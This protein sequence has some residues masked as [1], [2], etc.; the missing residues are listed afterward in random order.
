MPDARQPAPFA[1]SPSEPTPPLAIIAQA[2]FL[3]CSWTWCIGMFLPALLWRDLGPWSFAIFAIP[4]CIGAAAM[5]WVLRKPGAAQRLLDAHG[6]AIAAFSLVTLAFQWFFLAWMLAASGLSVRGIALV[7]AAIVTFFVVR[8]ARGSEHDHRGGV[9][10]GVLGVSIALG[11][12]WLGKDGTGGLATAAPR[13]PSEHLL[14][15]AMVCVLGFALCPYLDGTFLRTRATLAGSAGTFAFMLGFLVF[16]ALMIGLTFAYAPTIVRTA[17]ATKTALSP[18]ALPLVLALHVAVQLAFTGAVHEQVVER[19]SAGRGPGL[20][21]A[22]FIVGVV[23]AMVCMLPAVG[24]VHPNMPNSE[25]VYRAFMGAY[26]CVF[27]AYVWIV[28]WGCRAGGRAPVRAELLM[29]GTAV[30]MATPFYWLGFMEQR[31]WMLAPGVGIIVLAGLAARMLRKTT[32][33]PVGQGA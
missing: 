21:T 28:V 14:P 7:V 19:A 25:L 11:L 33:Q 2:A 16:F 3:A 12:W 31:T 6:P 27:P 26:G 15:M 8:A 4:N 18:A 23:L 32:P 29:W 30:V 13:L 22:A 10:L 24:R 17:E 1:S 9:A 5:G 20:T